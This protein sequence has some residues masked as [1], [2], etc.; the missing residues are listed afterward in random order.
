M[1]IATLAF[2]KGKG[3]FGDK[4]IRWW[5]KSDYSHTEL[6]INGQ[7]YSA[8]ERKG[9]KG[10]RVKSIVFNP[11]HWDFVEIEADTDYALKV[12]TKHKGK[13]YDWLGILFSQILP[14]NLDHPSRVFC[15]ELNAAMLG[16]DKPASYS[17]EKLYQWAKENGTSRP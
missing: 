17:P 6:V 1:A 13:G 10:A 15:S 8:S 12:F 3:L 2:Y 9:E 14:L 16:L 5:T 7:S 11:D 4:L